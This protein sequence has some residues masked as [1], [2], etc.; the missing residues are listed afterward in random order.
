MVNTSARCATFEWNSVHTGSFTWVQIRHKIL[1]TP[2]SVTVIRFIGASLGSMSLELVSKTEENYF[3]V[4]AL[5]FVSACIPPCLSLSG[6]L[7][8]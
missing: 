5:V 3:R 8:T 2:L 6:A 7:S 1:S 4:L